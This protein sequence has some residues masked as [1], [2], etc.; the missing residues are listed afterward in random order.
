[1][2]ISGGLFW[3][4]AAV[5][6]QFIPIIIN[7][8]VGISGYLCMLMGVTVLAFLLVLLALPETKVFT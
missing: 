3:T 4:A 7:S 2:A 5:S 1:M 8:E 6:I